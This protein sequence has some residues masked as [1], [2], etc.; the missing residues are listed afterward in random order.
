ME[1]KVTES[2]NTSLKFDNSFIDQLKGFYVPSK[3]EKAPRPQLIKFN[4]ELAE[5]LGWELK[6][7]SDDDLAQLLTGS[8][9]AEGAEPIA[10]VYAGHQFG[11]FNPV[12]G[13]GR[14]ILLGE[15]IDSN[16]QRRD[17]HLKGSGKTPFSRGGDGKAALGPVLREYILGE[18]MYALGIPA[19][20]GLAATLTGEKV[21]REQV[22]DGAVLARV[23]SSHIRVGT[24]QYYAARNEQDKVKQLADYTIERHFPKLAVSKKPYL[25]LLCAVRDRQAELIA[26]W[27]LVGFVHGVMNTDNVAISGETIDF[28]PCAFIDDY[29]E[30]AVYSSI[31]R[32]SRYALGNQAYIAQWNVARFA[33]TLLPLLGDDKETVI[34]NATQV[35]E[36]F[37]DVYGKYWLQGITAK[38][39]LSTIEKGD[40]ELANKLFSVLQDQHVDYTQF[41]RGLSETANGISDKV[42]ILFDNPETFDLWHS[43]WIQRLEID[44]NPLSDKIN[45]MNAIN[46]IYIPRNHLVEEAI[47]AAELSND[48]KPFEDLLSVLANPFEERVGLEKYTQGASKDFGPYKTFCGT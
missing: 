26:Q 43:Q 48:Y 35:I 2:I 14:A 29:D 4:R 11:G 24:F 17:I 37:V 23:A 9:P 19:T 13:D 20:R 38:L 10:Q 22:Q 41:F 27:V 39:G 12:L 21:I 18:A 47:K 3:G 36:G 46:P 7:L 45:L 32:Q 15:L 28:G 44:A 6:G 25:D 8:K 5:D 31:D 1:Y 40:V 30:N 33:E 34:K 42:R 16:G